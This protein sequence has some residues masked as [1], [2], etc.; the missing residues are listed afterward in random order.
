[1]EYKIVTVKC[2][3]YTKK[4]KTKKVKKVKKRKKKTKIKIDE[5]AE[6]WLE[7]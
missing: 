1:M 5:F 3:K 6:E 2:K 4:Q 7:F